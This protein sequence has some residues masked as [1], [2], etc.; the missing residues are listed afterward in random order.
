MLTVR[1]LI[2]SA[3]DKGIGLFANQKINKFEKIWIKDDV[4]FKIYTQEEYDKMDIIQKEFLEH[5]GVKEFDGTWSLDVDNMRFIN[6]SSNPNVEFT[7]FYPNAGIASKDIEMGEELTCDYTTFYD[8]KLWFK[9][10]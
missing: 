7:T 3:G 2:K 4:F 6:H 1:T 10:I 5:Y 9:E 8:K